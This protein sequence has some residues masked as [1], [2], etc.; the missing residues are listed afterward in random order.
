MIRT[1][2]TPLLALTLGL[3]LAVSGCGDDGDGSAA[4]DRAYNQTDA[5]FAASMV[6]HHEGGV[7]LGTLAAE[8][9]VNPQV[10]QLGAGIVDEQ[11]RELKTLERLVRDTKTRPI[12]PAA[13]AA[14]DKAD[15]MALKSASGEE[16]DKLW[17]DV[18]SAHHSAAIQMAEIEARGGKLPEATSLSKAI[19]RSQSKELTQFNQLLAQ[20]KS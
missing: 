2:K 12:M 19:A 5:A 16:F 17:L 11:E 9:G 15:M 10:K 4:A 13:I 14:R 1:W 18:I 8:K 7:E 20:M 6:H 3:A